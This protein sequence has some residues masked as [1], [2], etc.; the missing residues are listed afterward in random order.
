MIIRGTTPTF[1]L[2]VPN[3]VDL[4]TAENV[5]ATFRQGD[6]KTT[7]SG[8][9]IVVSAHSVDVYLDQTE[10][11]M[12]A[13]GAVEIQ[14]NW[15]FADGTRAASTIATATWDDNLVKRVLE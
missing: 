10:S 13:P 1:T 12:F 9:D 2:T 5:Y 15:T 8:D 6:K 11:L 14:L 4:T 3:T 7:K